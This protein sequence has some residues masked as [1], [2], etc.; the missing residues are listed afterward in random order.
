MTVYVVTSGEYSDYHIDAIFSTMEQAELYCAVHERK[1][2]NPYIEEWETDVVKMESCVPVKKLWMA[3]IGIDGAVSHLRSQ[4]TI[5]SKK[6]VEPFDKRIG[7]SSC[8]A[9]YSVLVTL[10]KDS[11]EE[12]ALKVMFD[13]LAK[14]KAEHCGI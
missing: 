4:L 9:G 13:Y 5:E 3:Y 1:L 11:T 6:Q 2:D 12:L 8:R 14:W 7:W 10:D